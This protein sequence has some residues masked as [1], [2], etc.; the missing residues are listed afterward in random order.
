[1]LDLQEMA[2]PHSA[3][4]RLPA[5]PTPL[6][7]REES[8]ATLCARLRDPD[9]RLM[10]LLGLAG[11]GK[12]RLAIYAAERLAG[13]FAGIGF[14]DLT[15]V[16]AEGS[17]LP[18][19]AAAL[20]IPLP[21]GHAEVD[22]LAAALGERPYLLVLDN[23]EHIAAIGRDLAALLAASPRL[24]VLATSRVAL[25]LRWEH[26]FPVEPLAVPESG[27]ESSP[28]ALA[29]SP[30][31][32][33]FVERVQAVQPG[34]R[35]TSETAPAVA[36]LCR[37]LDGLPLALELAAA[38][39]LVLS[40][41][42][43]LDALDRPLDL[44]ASAW[45]D[46]P[47]RQRSLRAAF[48][49]SVD[50]LPV[51]EATLFRQLAVF[52]DGATLEAIQAICLAHRAAE[53]QRS[54]LALLASLV[55]QSLLLRVAPDAGETRFRLLEPL[56][57]VAWER[58]RDA[59]EDDDTAGRHARHYLAFAERMG[60]GCHEKS[61]E[62]MATL[63]QVERELGNLRAARDR[64]AAEQG[65]NESLRLAAALAPFFLSRGYYGEGQR[66][67]QPA[68]AAGR[69]G[70]AEPVQMA[71]ALL[72]AGRI[73]E[74]QGDYGLARPATAES[75][76]LYRRL[77]ERSAL[78]G[79][80]N[81]YACIAGDTL[82]DG[83]VWG[84][85]DESRAI[86][87]ELGDRGGE[88]R[89]LNARGELARLRGDYEQAAALYQESLALYRDIEHRGG[90][91]ILQHNLGYVAQHQ[92]EY[93]R[94]VQLFSEGITLYRELRNTRLLAVCLAAL[95]AVAMI[96]QPEQAARL[97]AAAEAHLERM[98][99]VME[100][101]DRLEH[102]RNV[103]AVR[104]SLGEQAF[105]AAWAEGRAMTLERALAFVEAAIQQH[106]PT[107]PAARTEPAARAEE[108]TPR[109]REV[110]MLVARGL[111]N[112][113][114]ASRLVIAERTV[115]KHVGNILGKLGF[116][117]RAQVAAW[118]VEQGLQALH[119]SLAASA[120]GEG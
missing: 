95:A 112:R 7:G 33:L 85:L 39:C 41:A 46:A 60:P 31:A 115:D 94:A 4:P 48:G 35:L 69:E 57:A 55:G 40:P 73:A 42:A 5:Q 17:L 37:R 70:G 101:A 87:Q 45:A 114:I 14:V 76:V 92:L 16:D 26:L 71:A 79:A 59:G 65:V 88:A 66:W 82:P 93:A 51:E 72:A 106:A 1:M 54:P 64:F 105:Q 100:R 110:A 118:T 25:R 49:W 113:Q 28:Q 22:A 12:T 18:A 96:G 2:Q 80:L 9:V 109:E 43:L 6:F 53:S 86:Y 10:T 19:V 75:V 90:M 67:L 24:T 78:A 89:V 8:A 23:C 91:A 20:D 120:L 74:H 27:I 111:T 104:A 11:V 107:P 13:S 103:A 61:P 116:A 36:A 98:G 68:I 81:W 21:D 119:A 62:T 108:L 97:F 3:R 58:L 77:D 30:A 52:V 63:A 102:D 83:E 47:A 15:G 56:R 99:A 38:Q 44:L 50:Q 84:L 29:A 34:F 32:A 117:S